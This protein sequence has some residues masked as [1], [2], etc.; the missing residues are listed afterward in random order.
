MRQKRREQIPSFGQVT[1]DEMENW[2]MPVRVDGRT[3]VAKALKQFRRALLIQL[4]DD[5]TPLVRAQVELAAQLKWRLLTMDHAFGESCDMTAHDSRVY[6]GWANSLS[7]VLAKLEPRP[8]PES[9]RRPG[10]PSLQQFVGGNGH[11]RAL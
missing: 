1:K 3:L 7:R 4:G 2:R 5:I 8:P 10:R 6:L 9:K 11:A